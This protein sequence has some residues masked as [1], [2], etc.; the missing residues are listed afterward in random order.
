MAPRRPREAGA[1]LVAFAEA[2][3]D[4]AATDAELDAAAAAYARA[5]AY[6]GGMVPHTAAVRRALLRARR[7]IPGAVADL[8]ALALARRGASDEDCAAR[9]CDVGPGV[10]DALAA[11]ACVTTAFKTDTRA[12][13]PSGAN[14]S[15]MPTT[16]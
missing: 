16:R 5:A 2:S 6:A 12:S 3:D 10:A 8:D 9:G 14:C 1:L 7:D 15:R 13:P 4:A 11:D